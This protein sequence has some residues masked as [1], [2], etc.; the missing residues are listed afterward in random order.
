MSAE[1]AKNH[2]LGQ[3]GCPKANCAQAILKGFQKELKIEDQIIVNFG[4]Y[5]AGRAPQG[6][7]GALYATEEL[8]KQL[9]KSGQIKE[10]EDYFR[11][12]AGAINCREIK[13]NTKYPCADCVLTSASFLEKHL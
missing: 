7:C 1:K 13:G 5:G 3:N 2:Y 6:K 4:S 8:L 10:F 11:K 9:G 12:K